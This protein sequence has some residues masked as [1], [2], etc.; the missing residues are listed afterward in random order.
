MPALPLGGDPGLDIYAVWT[1]LPRVVVFLVP[2]PPLDEDWR[3]V[4][5]AENLTV[6][7]ITYFSFMGEYFLIPGFLTKFIVVSLWQHHCPIMAHPASIE[8]NASCRLRC[9]GEVEA[10]Q[11]YQYMMGHVPLVIQY[12]RENLE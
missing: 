11:G 2:R 3:G 9:D 8:L 1:M 5:D 10:Q 4:D 7:R 6:A 12:L